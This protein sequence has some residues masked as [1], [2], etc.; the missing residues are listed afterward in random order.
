MKKEIYASSIAYFVS[1]I[2]L[3]GCSGKDSS[4]LKAFNPYAKATLTAGTGLGALQLGKTTLGW[5]AQNLGSG[6]VSA[7]A[8]D[9]SAIELT[10]LNGEVS[11][12]F[13]VVGACE[14]ETGAPR[15]RLQI[16]QDLKAFLAK[17]PGCNDLRLSS[18]SVATRDHNKADAFFQGV[19]DRGVQLWS[20]ITDATR[21]G[22]GLNRAGQLVA[23]EG[24]TTDEL[25]RI[26]FP[27]GIYFYYPAGAGAT[28]AEITSGRPL[29]PERLREIE[30]SAKQAAT[31]A[32]IKRITIF[33]PD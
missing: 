19:T 31:D 9:Q 5:V 2:L 18:L 1:L 3:A 26:E 16:S 25:N 13:I 8:S 32:T 23:G 33:A 20:P 22:V 17:Y 6:S 24:Y 12:L 15:S 14:Q 30:A 27:G 10:F 7:I 21:H 4:E 29:S 11:L 28:A